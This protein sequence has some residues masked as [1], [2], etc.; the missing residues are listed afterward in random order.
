MKILVFLCHP[1]QFYCY[2]SSIQNWK[3]DGHEVYVLIKTKDILEK[4]L[5]EAKIP[6]YNINKKAHRKHKIGIVWDIIVRDWKLFWFSIKHKVDVL[7]GTAVEVVHIGWLLNKPAINIVED[8]A[9]IIP[10]FVRLVNP[11]LKI[12]LSPVSCNNGKLENRTIKYAGYQKLAYLHPNYFKPNKEVVEKYFNA[13]E[14]YFV[15]RF[16]QLTAYHDHGVNGFTTEVTQHVVDLLSPHG[17][18]YISSEKELSPQFEQYRMK[19]NPLDIHHILYYSTLYAGDSQSMA[20]EASVLGVP[21]IRFN[22][23]VGKRKIGVL[24]ELE[25]VYGLTYAIHSS[26]AENLY[27]KIEELLV[28]TNIKE[29]WQKRRQKMLSEKIDVTAFYTWFVE[30]Y[31]E[32]QDIMKQNPD[33]Q[34]RFK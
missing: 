31:P 34:Y 32:S 7:T 3:N 10:E 28:I 25:H 15:L 2:R 14:P 17:K 5:Q 6:Y 30:N 13:N 26:Q 33:Y 18:V 8:D 21:S 23:F 19:I 11:F 4:L 22:D 9:E 20:V 24:E 27:A 1:S 29:E 12:K 16:A